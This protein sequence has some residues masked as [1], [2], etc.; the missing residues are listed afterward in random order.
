MYDGPWVNGEQ[1]GKGKYFDENGNLR[2]FGDWEDGKTHGL[3]TY[4]YEE[5]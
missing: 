5:T 4:Y 3:G 1:S 2:Y